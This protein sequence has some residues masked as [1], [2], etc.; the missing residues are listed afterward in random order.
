[1]E[2][3]LCPDYALPINNDVLEKLLDNTNHFTNQIAIL[4]DLNRHHQ[5]TDEDK[6]IVA[7][8]DE[9]LRGKQH[10][11]RNITNRPYLMM[12]MNRPHDYP[13]EKIP[14]VVKE[15][16]FWCVCAME[17]STKCFDMK[18]GQRTIITNPWGTAHA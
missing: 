18:N 14:K 8:L 9:R 12:I 6:E 2:S 3:E 4:N 17:E 7:V 11:A 15:N 1:M 13:L 10:G 5:E 16:A